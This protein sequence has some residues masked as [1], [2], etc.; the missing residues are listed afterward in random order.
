M[1]NYK[2]IRLLLIVISSLLVI[3]IFSSFISEN[4]TF[5]SKWLYP[6][7]SD[8]NAKSLQLIFS[9]IGGI[10]ILFGLY[11]SY[12]RV[13]SLEK[14]VKI[15]Q[16]TLLGQNK[17]IANQTTE[18]ELSRKAQINEQFKIA[19]EHLG[20]SNKSVVIGGFIELVFIA[21][22][23]P[24]KYAE[25]V[26][27]LF[28]SY[29]QSEASL[30][31]KENEIDFYLVENILK[32]LFSSLA[33]RNK[34]SD[35]SNLN[36]RYCNFENVNFE[37]VN[38]SGSYMPLKLETCL[39]NHCRFDKT[40]FVNPKIKLR[41]ITAFQKEVEETKKIG[42]L[43]NITFSNCYGKFIYFY[44]FELK[45]IHFNNCENLQRFQFIRCFL[46]KIKGDIF[47]TS[48][49]HFFSEFISVDISNNIKDL[50]LYCCDFQNIDF[51]GIVAENWEVAYCMFTSIKV[52]NFILSKSRIIQPRYYPKKYYRICFVPT[53][54]FLEN[55]MDFDIKDHPFFNNFEGKIIVG[56]SNPQHASQVK[57]VLVELIKK[58]DF[59]EELG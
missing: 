2:N 28:C 32:F 14:S 40:K 20:N 11:I 50:N 16:E 38:F 44:F 52:E 23:D 37:N 10:V 33:L 12:K 26:H 35:L 53:K 7:D 21:E 1:I 58:F 43:S 30:R 18:I 13:V 29:L 42:V 6:E 48:T 24:E 47:H 34:E 54:E 8:K 36:F 3:L 15:Q 9:I 56:K 27:K 31:K 46:H 17:V 39:F 4:W 49:S 45:N 51:S 19:V 57:T 5:L 25:I 59:L 55:H 41:F 22:E